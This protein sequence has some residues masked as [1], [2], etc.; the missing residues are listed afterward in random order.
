I[1]GRL[2]KLAPSARQLIMVSAVLGNQATTQRLWQVAEVGVQAG[3]EALEEA[4]SSGILREEGAVGGLA[5]G[6]GV[7]QAGTYRFAHDLIR[8]GVHTEPGEAR[9]QVIHPTALARLD[10]EAARPPE[11]A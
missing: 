11:L 1:Q 6:L 3:V 7:G 4:V 10:S 5:G 2:A 8:A 9:R